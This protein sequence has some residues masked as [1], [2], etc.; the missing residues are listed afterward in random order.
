MKNI[1]IPQ[2]AIAQIPPVTTCNQSTKFRHFELSRIIH[3][4][5]MTAKNIPIFEKDAARSAPN[6]DTYDSPA[7]RL[8]LL[9]LQANKCIKTKSK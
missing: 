1:T 4:F 8:P 3:F 6:A 7:E 5:V 9:I 2:M